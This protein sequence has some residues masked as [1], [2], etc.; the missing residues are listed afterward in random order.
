M[1]V[2]KLKP[3]DDTKVLLLKI[4]FSNKFLNIC[5]MKTVITKKILE[6][7]LEQGLSGNQKGFFM[8]IL[9]LK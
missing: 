3:S 1:S 4:W 8:P 7:L 9:K 2:S 5:S 6:N